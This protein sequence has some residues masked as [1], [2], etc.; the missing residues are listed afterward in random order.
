MRDAEKRFTNLSK[1]PSLARMRSNAWPGKGQPA[2]PEPAAPAQAIADTG[3]LD[4]MRGWTSEVGLAVMVHRQL[5]HA[6]VHYADR[7]GT[8]GADVISVDASG[9][10][11]LWDSK[12]RSADSS[13]AD[14]GTFRVDQG[15]ASP[16]LRN[17]LRDALYAVDNPNLP[18][19]VRANAVKNLRL[20]NFNT[21]TIGDGASTA[22]HIRTHT[23][24][25]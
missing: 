8:R 23:G 4:H 17:A 20:G 18:G 2:L 24:V 13:V 3:R 5:G 12:F 11:F 25:R 14:S 6:V 19:Q 7:P 15:Q 1:D 21:V 9:R 10:V 16:R 22:L